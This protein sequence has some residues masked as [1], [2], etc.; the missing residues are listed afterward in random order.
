MRYHYN[1]RFDIWICLAIGVLLSFI[2]VKILEAVLPK[3]Y[4]SYVEEHIVEDGEIGGVA[5][6]EIF[7]AQNVEDLLSHDTFTVVSPRY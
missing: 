3:S 6:E 2:P 7:R 4:E 5:G 1:M